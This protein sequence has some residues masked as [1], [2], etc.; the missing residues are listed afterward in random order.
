MTGNR[1]LFRNLT[2]EAWQN[3]GI[4]AVVLVYLA[5]VVLDIAWGNLFGNLGV[6]FAAFWSAGHIANQ[7]G[8]GAVYD[9][10]VVAEV[11]RQFLPAR[12]LMTDAV[13]ILPTAYLPPFLL[14]FRALALLPPAAAATV[15]IALNFLGSVLYIGYFA[16]SI[17]GRHVRTLLL[18]LLMISV[19][20]F[21]N[22]FLG[23]AN[24]W[25]MICIGGSILAN[26]AGREYRSGAWLA[27][28]L[29]KPQCLFLIVPAILLQ[30][31]WKAAVGMLLAGASIIL[32][33]WFLAGTA[34]LADLWRLWIGYVGGLPTNDPQLMMNWRM[35]GIHLQG[36]VGSG[37]AQIIVIAG[38]AV[39]IL[40]AFLLSMHRF[41]PMDPRSTIVILGVMA[42]TA[43]ISWHSHVHMAMILVPPLLALAVV[44]QVPFGRVLYTW[45]WLP[46][47]I[48]IVRIVLAA[49]A[50]AGTLPV[51]AFNAL[52]LLGGLGLFVVNLMLVVWALRRLAPWS[53]AEA[54]V[55]A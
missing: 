42:A 46:V 15:W 47:A 11:Q 6:D 48:H 31:R 51:A 52:D 7:Y 22:T 9:L 2:R 28:L 21:Q 13:R 10:E 26:R 25:L 27:G 5:Q 37:W 34:A 18:V 36:L 43:L 45:V 49:V 44:P 4:A 39:T 3:L 50:R 19:P 24:L 41:D 17:A 23:Q 33:S 1:R 30:R 53:P 12:A 55:P 14:P 40:A 35:I 32:A 8:N 29:L 20:I 16:A 38:M 54:P